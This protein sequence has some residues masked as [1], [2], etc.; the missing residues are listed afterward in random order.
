[1][2]KIVYVRFILWSVVITFAS[3][4]ISGIMKLFVIEGIDGAGKS[5]QIKN[6][7]DFLSEKGYRY[8]YLHFPRTDAP[9]FGELIAR[10]LRGEFGALNDVDPYL[11]AMLYAG[12]RRDA[13]DIIY[14]WL[15]EGKIVLLDRY[16]YSNIAYQCAKKDNK[17]EQEIL[18][19]WIL[20]LEFNHFRIPRPD[21]N[22]Y[23]D[24]PSIFTESKL[25][26]T[27]TGSDRSYLNGIKDI[28]E[29]DLTFQKKVRG[30]Y[31][32]TARSD[33]KLTVIDCSNSDGSMLPPEKVFDKII[34]ILTSNN[35]L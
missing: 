23:L 14:K 11:V 17:K 16:T 12:D 19:K 15:G 27:R 3:I 9:F 24:V 6:L 18:M 13:S 22:I 2:I 4:L 29:T 10:F 34:N 32:D 33:D 7:Q 20:D 28:H 5:T 8:E 21:I 25:T 1:M 31:L 26:D 35:L 30:V